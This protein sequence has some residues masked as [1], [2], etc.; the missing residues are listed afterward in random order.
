MIPK[1]IEE[2]R[3]SK[4]MSGYKTDEVDDFCDKVYNDYIKFAELIKVKQEKIEALEAKL[5]DTELNADSINAVLISAQKLADSI[6]A[7]AKSKAEEIVER[8]QGIRCG[9]KNTSCPNELA[10]ALTEY[11]KKVGD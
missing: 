10:T 6:V 2:I 4:S 7:E 9:F 5:R 8:L 11:L 1:E 3:F